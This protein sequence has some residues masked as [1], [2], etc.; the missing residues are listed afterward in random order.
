MQKEV[1]GAFSFLNTDLDIAQI[2]T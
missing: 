2:R 1:Q